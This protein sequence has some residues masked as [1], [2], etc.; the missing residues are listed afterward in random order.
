[1]RAAEH[2]RPTVTLGALEVSRLGLDAALAACEER[3]RRGAGGSACFVNVHTLT[4]GSRD[5]HLREAMHAAS[6]LFADGVP[7]L[8]LARAKRA[9]IATRV[10]GAA[11]LYPVMLCRAH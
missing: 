4:E 1:M 7:L 3:V 5:A 9:P 8:W 11:F 6:F 10:W 2:I